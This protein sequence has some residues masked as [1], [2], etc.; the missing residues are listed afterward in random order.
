MVRTVYNCVWAGIYVYMYIL[1]YIYLHMRMYG[2]L[3]REGER[4]REV[5]NV[6]KASAL[7]PVLHQTHDPDRGSKTAR[8]VLGLLRNAPG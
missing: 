6:E 4:E 1:I 8:A 5:C 3:E 7:R 2:H